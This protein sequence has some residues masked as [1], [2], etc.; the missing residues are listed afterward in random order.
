[1][2]EAPSQSKNFHRIMKKNLW[3]SRPGVLLNRGCILTLWDLGWSRHRFST[4]GWL[5]DF[6]TKRGNS[7]GAWV[8]VFQTGYESTRRIANRRG[9][10]IGA[11]GIRGHASLVFVSVAAISRRPEL[12]GNY[13]H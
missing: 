11:S 13:K 7:L 4:L 5:R 9:R 6:H 10:F 12:A 8:L 1:M 2:R 3:V